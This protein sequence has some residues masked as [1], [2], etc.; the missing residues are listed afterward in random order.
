MSPER[1]RARGINPQDVRIST[2][3]GKIWEVYVP[4]GSRDRGRRVLS[5]GTVFYA[6]RWVGRLEELSGG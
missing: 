4:D 5:A 3:P 2:G 6:L 1:A